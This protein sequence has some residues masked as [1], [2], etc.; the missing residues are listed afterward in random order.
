[1]TNSPY[2]G[3]DGRARFPEYWSSQPLLDDLEHF[4]LLAPDVPRQQVAPLLE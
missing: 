1:M 4:V 2:P 3:F